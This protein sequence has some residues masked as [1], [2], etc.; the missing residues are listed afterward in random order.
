[1]YVS[2]KGTAGVAVAVTDLGVPSYVA[3]VSGTVT[4]TEAGIA[5]ADC[6]AV[7]AW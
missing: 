5:V 7:A 2:E 6:A 3:V 4:E 1:V